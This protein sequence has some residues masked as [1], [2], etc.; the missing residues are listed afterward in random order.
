MARRNPKKD[1]AARRLRPDLPGPRRAR[2]GLDDHNRLMSGA[3][4]DAL[5]LIGVTSLWLWNLAQ[6]RHAAA[7]CVDGCLTLHYALAEYGIT[8]RVEAITIAIGDLRPSARPGASAVYGQ[9]PRYNADGTF[10]GHTVL[11]VT[12]AGRFID[13]TIQ[14]FTEIPVTPATM[15]PLQAPLPTPGGLGGAP[16]AV[17]RGDH[18][19]V[20]YSQLPV[21]QQRQAWRSPRL[22]ARDG[23]Y[24]AAGENLAA[25]TLDLL[26]MEDMRPK[27][28][29]APYPRLR[30]LLE[31]LHGMP[32]IADSKGYRFA[33]PATGKEIRLHDIA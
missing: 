3:S 10:N 6:D 8:S 21:A 20:I 23:D 33:D 32:A 4:P 25:N 2:F 5:P 11:V 7:H 18:H 15:L 19:A 31:A 27:A 24:R 28:M 1:K 22:A 29:Q 13:P 17:G 14:Q 30:V 12:G 9:D 16:I 26:Q